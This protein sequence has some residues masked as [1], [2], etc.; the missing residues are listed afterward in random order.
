MELI[1]SDII[2]WEGII[3][4]WSAL[5]YLIPLDEVLLATPEEI[6]QRKYTI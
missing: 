1:N 2:V 3:C 6:K 4:E 5:K